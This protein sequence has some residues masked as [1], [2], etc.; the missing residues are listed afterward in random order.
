MEQSQTLEGFLN[1]TSTVFPDPH[2]DPQHERMD[3]HHWETV[4][5]V[6][7]METMQTDARRLLERVGAWEDYG[8]AGW[9]KDGNASVFSSMDQVLHK[10]GA[11]TLLSKYYTTQ[12]LQDMV[13]TRYAGDYNLSILELEPTRIP[14]L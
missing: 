4:N 7:H 9:G 5:F 2:W 8:A 12:R 13:D 11:Q 14:L 6:G 1:L 3:P 10:M